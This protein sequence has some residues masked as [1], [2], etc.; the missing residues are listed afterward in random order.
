MT[1]ET[2]MTVVRPLLFRSAGFADTDPGIR[3]HEKN[4]YFRF[5]ES[6]SGR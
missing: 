5:R 3:S 6:D 1:G 4:S 2:M